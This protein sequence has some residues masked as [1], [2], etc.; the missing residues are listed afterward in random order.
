[1]AILE[2]IATVIIGV[3]GAKYIDKKI[4]ATTDKKTN[5]IIVKSEG[6]E[7]ARL[8]NGDIKLE[9]FDIFSASIDR[10]TTN[11]QEKPDKPQTEFSNPFKRDVILSSLSVVP[12]ANFQTKGKAL[13]KIG[14]NSFT[15]SGAAL[16]DVDSVNIPLPASGVKVERDDKIQVFIWNTVD[17]TDITLTSL[18]GLGGYHG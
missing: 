13:I 11:V 2:N 17:N 10:T 4:E 1:M 6:Q 14:D 8:P 15:I 9:P 5:E 18:V 12:N 3:L 16:T 7:I